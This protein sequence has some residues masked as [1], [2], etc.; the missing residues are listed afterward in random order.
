MSADFATISLSPLPSSPLPSARTRGELLEATEQLLEKLRKQVAH[1]TGKPLA[2]AEI[3]PPCS[4]TTSNRTG[5]MPC[6]R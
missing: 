5:Q 4:G 3:G 6:L 2:A 1:R